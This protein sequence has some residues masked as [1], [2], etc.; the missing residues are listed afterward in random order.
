M[1]LSSFDRDRADPFTAAMRATS[2]AMVMTDP[3]LPDNPIV[4]ANDAFLGLTG[5]SSAEVIGH[6]C[7]FLH[8]PRTDPVAVAKIR[9]AIDAKMNISIDLGNYRKDG[10]SFHNGLHISPVFNEAGELRLFFASQ[11]DLTDRYR[12]LGEWEQANRTL[13]D[14]LETTATLVH[15]IDHRV[16]N[17][18]Q[19][20]SA[21]ILLQS[22]DQPDP[23]LRRGLTDTLARVEALST[24]HRRFHQSPDVSQFDVADYVRDLLGD[25]VGATGRTDIRLDL[26]LASAIVP[27]SKSAAIALLFNEV[28]T[29]ALKHAF[30]AGSGGTLRVSMVSAD[31]H[32]AAIVEDDGVGMPQAQRPTTSFGQSLIKTLARQLRAEVAVK[33]VEPSGTRIEIRLPRERKVMA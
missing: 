13:S 30:P 25:L 33:R 28:F 12:L 20:V 29:N 31:D 5:Y 26:D 16:K 6:N 2:V 18:L 15:E 32:L 17:N 22:L 4:F 21:M 9:D 14:A 8:G 1:T 19:M 3:R 24:V 7:R 11:L 10:S 27:A 23:E